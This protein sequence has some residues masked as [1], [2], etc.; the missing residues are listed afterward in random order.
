MTL[1]KE[2]KDILLRLARR[3]IEKRLLK[4]GDP[5]ET[6]PPDALQSGALNET[7]GLFVTIHSDGLL[8]GC[9]GAFTSDKPLR[10]KVGEMALSAAFMDPRFSPLEAGELKHIEIEISVLSPL[11]EITDVGEIEIGRHGIYII[12]GPARGVL[13]PQVAMEHNFDRETFLDH[14]CMKA[15]LEPGCWK[16][17]VRILIFEAEIFKEE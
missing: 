6:A 17:G 16:R 3:A 8:R 9:I 15:G 2:E 13:L 14:T 4:S 10:E 11:R 5:A 12:D 7:R 1:T